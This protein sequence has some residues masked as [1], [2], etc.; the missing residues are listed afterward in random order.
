MRKI[1]CLFALLLW[2]NLA[3]TV[4]AQTQAGSAVDGQARYMRLCSRCHTASPDYRAIRAANSP[5]TLRLAANSVSG[6]GFLLTLLTASDYD[7]IAAFIGN[8][9]LRENVVTVAPAGAGQGFIS[10]VPN[11]VACGGTC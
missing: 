7:N 4:D 6:M 3:P 1:L 5:D 9:A 2:I 8:E 10:S 11:T